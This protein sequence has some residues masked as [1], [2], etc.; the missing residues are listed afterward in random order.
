MKRLGLL[1]VLAIAASSA[2]LVA[3]DLA[4]SAADADAIVE[5]AA[6]PN[7]TTDASANAEHG[8]DPFVRAARRSTPRDVPAVPPPT[9]DPLPL[10]LGPFGSNVAELE[11]RANAGDARAA[12][13]LA[14]GY[15]D[16]R[17]F[18]PLADAADVAEQAEEA[19]ARSLDL[20]EQIRGQ[21]NV[22]A[23]EHDVDEI[24][25]P[26]VDAA[27]SNILARRWSRIERCTG[28]D[29]QAAE[30]WYAW[31]TRAVELGDVEASLE[32][33][34]EVLKNANLQRVAEVPRER[35]LAV[36]AAARVLAKGDPRALVAIGE[37]LDAGFFTQ[38]DA[39]HAYAY[40]FAATQASPGYLASPTNR[41]SLF[42][43]RAGET[44]GDLLPRMLT[45]FGATLD[46]Q[47]RA[48]A[49]RVGAELY[50]RCCD[51][52]SS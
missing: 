5:P 28:V 2:Y 10:P 51:E 21:L 7:E 6:E 46:P 17:G 41:P 35:N 50:A 37:M 49:E 24:P 13:A 11:R 12:K 4:Q 38:P 36:S 27:Y 9:A 15:K 44:M 45:R 20:L 16:C 52:E 8:A 26:S 29:P 42:G 18:Q 22:I 48:E 40:V 34:R 31:Y 47:Q 19:T 43:L 23:R 25:E 39:F 1:I 14:D 30:N 3:R 32:Y 33:W